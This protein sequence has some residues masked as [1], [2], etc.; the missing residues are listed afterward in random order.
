M[1]ES[2]ENVTFLESLLGRIASSIGSEDVKERL[3]AARAI[4]RMRYSGEANLIDC[5]AQAVAALGP[6]CL[7]QVVADLGDHEEKCHRILA[8]WTISKLGS[9][10]STHVELMAAHIDQH[11]KET[12]LALVAI[13]GAAESHIL[14]ALRHEQFGT[15]LAAID[16][17]GNPIG[18]WPASVGLKVVRELVSLLTNPTPTVVDAATEAL[19]SLAA[20]HAHIVEMLMILS[21]RASR[22]G[23]DKIDRIVREY[24]GD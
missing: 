24:R 23:R 7:G 22:M 21:Q 9:R 16:A 8:A 13:G 10:A 3:W 20:G 15:R 2:D 18:R 19:D 17:I 12:I 1:Q 5:A 4:A 11:P 14:T 6:E